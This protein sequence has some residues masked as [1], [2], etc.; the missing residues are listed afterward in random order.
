VSC[1]RTSAS[2]WWAGLAVLAFLYIATPA[3]AQTQVRMACQESAKPKA[4][5]DAKAALDSE[6]DELGPR[7]KLADALVD[8]GCYQDAVAVLEAGQTAH[9]HSG[10]LTGKLRDVR[11]MITEQTYIEGLTQAEESAKQQRNVLR[12]TK[13]ADTTACDDA[14]KSKPD[15]VQLVLAKAD[16]LAQ[17]NR[18]PEAAAAYR[19]AAQLNPANEAVKAKL[20]SVESLQA[21]NQPA[22]AS[23]PPA[24]PPAQPPAAQKNVASQKPRRL[25]SAATL[26]AGNAA[27]TGGK[28]AG[29]LVAQNTASTAAAS[30]GAPEP[31]AQR[32]YSNDAPAGRTN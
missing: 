15:D 28:S 2:A 1:P 10:E 14:L 16:A 23:E 18:L 25:A 24:E 30:I 17:A 19:R 11:S 20:A 31:A 3:G 8:Q 26:G 12:C 7:L 9:P 32:T 4:V 22:H 5:L 27:S 13:L 29:A 6:P 21:N